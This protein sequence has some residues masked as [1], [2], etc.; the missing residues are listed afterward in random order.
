MGVPTGTSGQPARSTAASRYRGNEGTPAVRRANRVESCRCWTQDISGTTVP[1]VWGR[2]P[3]L[4]WRDKNLAVPFGIGEVVE[5]RAHCVQADL[6]GDHRGG[7]DLALGQRAQ[8]RG[9]LIRG[10]GQ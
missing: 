3:Q 1:H 4:L 6:S 5:C 8:R 9:E 7:V 2:A 10:L